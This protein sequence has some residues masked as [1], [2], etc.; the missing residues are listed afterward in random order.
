[1]KRCMIWILIPI[2]LAS[3]SACAGAGG[4]VEDQAGLVAALEAAGAQVE[5]GDPISQPFF[6]PEGQSLLVNEA[7]IQV[8]EYPDG[9]AM[10]AEASQVAPD[11]TSV[12]TT[13]VDW[14]APPHFYKSGRILVLY[15]GDDQ[16]V[17]DQLN[18][19]LGPQFAG[20]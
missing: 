17:L 8:F 3:L 16:A 20:Q 18:N 2:A 10:E 13:M 4:G 19:V 14:F 9:Q 11:G 12:G 5:P 6:T 7:D 15:V 1:M